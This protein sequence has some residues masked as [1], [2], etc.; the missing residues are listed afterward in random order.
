M[1][2]G[3][4]HDSR[5][6]SRAEVVPHFLRVRMIHMPHARAPVDPTIS[7]VDLVF[8]IPLIIF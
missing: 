7:Y 6:A 3:G 4:K 2:H 5:R 1:S 8:S